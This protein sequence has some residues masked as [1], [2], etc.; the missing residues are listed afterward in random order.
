MD[1]ALTFD[2]GTGCCHVTIRVVKRQRG[3]KWVWEGLGE[4]RENLYVVSRCRTGLEELF[5][6]AWVGR[7]QAEGVGCLPENTSVGVAARI[8]GS[9]FNGVEST[10]TTVRRN[11][12]DP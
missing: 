3:E 12:G 5:G 2:N 11:G 1:F 9:E 7:S 6:V 8:S 4:G 10:I